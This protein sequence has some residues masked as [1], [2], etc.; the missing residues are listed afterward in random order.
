MDMIT[1]FRGEHAFLSNFFPCAINLDGLTYS[2]G[3]AAFQAQKCTTIED[4]ARYTRVSPSEAKY[5]G[6]RERIDVAAWNAKSYNVMLAVV[7]AKF[8]N[9]ALAQKLLNTGDAIIVEGNTWHDN[10]WG[11][12]TCPKCASKTSRNQLGMILMT[13]REELKLSR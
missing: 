13:V 7:R 6:K 11:R 5:M 3:E 12:C 9:P 2:S 10:I 8:A 1:S 4:K